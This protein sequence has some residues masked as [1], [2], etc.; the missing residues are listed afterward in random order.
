MSQVDPQAGLDM[1][2]PLDQIIRREKDRMQLMRALDDPA[3]KVHA[4]DLHVSG[5]ISIS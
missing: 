3:A 5:I 2:N 1:S 4:M